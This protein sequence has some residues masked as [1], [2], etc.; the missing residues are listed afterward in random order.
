MGQF[1]PPYGLAPDL[2]ADAPKTCPKSLE[3]WSFVGLLG[4]GQS[5][6][7]GGGVRPIGGAGERRPELGK[8]G[9]FGYLFSGQ[10]SVLLRAFS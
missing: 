3:R 7:R 1:W 4:S 2:S 8:A 5:G 6:P 9:L 10:Q